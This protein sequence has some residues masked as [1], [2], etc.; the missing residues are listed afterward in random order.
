MLWFHCH[1]HTHILEAQITYWLEYLSCTCGD[2]KAARDAYDF[3]RWAVQDERIVGMAPWNWGGCGL[4]TSTK[5][6]IGTVDLVESKAA[7]VAIG[8]ARLHEKHE[9]TP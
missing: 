8:K 7:W 1:C 9:R 3:Y 5:D 4:C 2:A 6:E